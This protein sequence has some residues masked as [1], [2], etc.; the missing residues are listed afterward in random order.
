MHTALL[1]PADGDS[2]PADEP[3]TANQASTPH[4]EES[5]SLLVCQPADSTGVPRF[6]STADCSAGSA[7]ASSPLAHLHQHLMD[8]GWRCSQSL[9]A[10]AAHLCLR[11]YQ[12]EPSPSLTTRGAQCCCIDS[13]ASS[14]R[15]RPHHGSCQSS[16]RTLVTVSAV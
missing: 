16:G 7:S 12:P 8:A 15:R 11:V 1:T 14:S 5:S 3:S 13:E 2:Q 4:P 10:G 6:L 9:T